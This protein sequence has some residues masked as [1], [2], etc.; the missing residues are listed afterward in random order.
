MPCSRHA[1]PFTV[2]FKIG[3]KPEPKARAMIRQGVAMVLMNTPETMGS[4]HGNYILLDAEGTIPIDGTKDE[5]ARPYGAGFS[6]GWH[7][8]NPCRHRIPLKKT[9]GAYT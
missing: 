1:T 4:S 9:T 8:P 2:A 5:I 6:A 7:S 3:R